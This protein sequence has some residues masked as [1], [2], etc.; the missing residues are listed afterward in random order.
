MGRSGQHALIADQRNHLEVAKYYTPALS[1]TGQLELV[2]QGEP[3]IGCR[4]DL[5]WGHRVHVERLAG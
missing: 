4:L 5:E 2:Q 3:K 1:G